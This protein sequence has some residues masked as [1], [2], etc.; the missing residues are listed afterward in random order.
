MLRSRILAGAGF[1]AAA[2]AFALSPRSSALS[3][4][5]DEGTA[6]SVSSAIRAALD[7]SKPAIVAHWESK[8]GEHEWLEDVLGERAL[9]WVRDCNAKALE[10]LGG[11]PT[12]SPLYQRLFSILTSKEK[13]PYLRKIGKDY[14]NFWTDEDNPRGVWRRTD[15]ASYRAGTPKWETVLSIDDLNRAE[16][17][18]WVYKG[19]TLLEPRDGS[20]PT[21]TLMHL[22]RGGADAVMLREFDMVGKRFVPASEGGFIVPE[23][24]QRVDWQSEDVL[25]LGTAFP[26]DASAMTD[27]GYPRTIR[28]WRRGTPLADAVEVFAGRASDVSISGYVTRHRE[29]EFEW[30]NRAT[31][32]YT[33]EKHVRRVDAKTGQPL[34]AWCTL[35][36]PEDA[37]VSQ[38]GDQFLITLRSKWGVHRA[39]C[40]L[41]APAASLMQ[42]TSKGGG[43]EDGG[44]GGCGD[45]GAAVSVLFAPSDRS[46]LERGGI[47][48]TRNRLILS[49][50][51][52][53]RSQIRV[54]S[55]DD[56]TGAWR[57]HDGDGG[58]FETPQIEGVSVAA[59]DS[60]ADDRVWLTTWSYLSPTTLSLSD[61]GG[62]T[63]RMRTQ[64]QTLR[65]LPPMFDASTHEVCQGSATSKDGTAIPYFVV[66][67]KA[68]SSGPVP[69]L[70]YGYGGFQISM[71]PKYVATTGAAWLEEG[72][73]YVEAN[74]R[75]G[76]EF[77]PDWHQAAKREGRHKAYEDFEAVAMDL[78]QTGVTTHSMIACRGGSNGGLLVG[79]MLT[80]SPHLFG[81]V[82][83]A[84][85][86]LDMRRYNQLLAGASWMA[87]FGDPDTSDW[88]DFL[89]E[90]SP[91]HHI[92][93]AGAA[94]AAGETEG[95]PPLL[96]TTSTRD[97]RVH[98]Y[99]ARAFVRRL[100]ESGHEP[101]TTYYENIEGGHGGAADPKQSAFMLCLNFEFL[102]RT[103]GQSLRKPTGEGTK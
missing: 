31:S 85:P 19:H 103:V 66:R 101:T 53:V 95:Y 65:S 98:P 49:V 96:M 83:C 50:L 64:A 10:T 30:R 63:R 20:P 11:D 12:G 51:D 9:S 54:L 47:T 82:I 1:A 55:V 88:D 75:G 86:L 15:L 26:G 76:G 17:E 42:A 102:K 60:D 91:Y 21:R 56:A 36:V 4:D 28:E 29:F 73:C 43:D 81:A 70:L 77:G 34:S 67:P 99:H 39:G 59:V 84:V 57:Q 78:V 74:I 18:S 6:R 100:Q 87:E 14:Y 23:A 93:P 24:K 27:S 45:P 68:A 25:L 13:I 5:L 40:L 41:A 33:S 3:I 80:R 90:F 32:F 35:A 16:G 48:V 38:F 94:G 71:T 58:G 62:G 46:A 97:D 89:Y 79:N 52:N 22:S 72:G 92:S 37:T 61:A 8:Q 69:T 7:S 2:S 44:G